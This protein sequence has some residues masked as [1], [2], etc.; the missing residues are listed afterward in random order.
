MTDLEKALL[1]LSVISLISAAATAKLSGR[2][3]E[4]FREAIL[5]LSQDERWVAQL[6]L[7]TGHPQDFL[8]QLMTSLATGRPLFRPTGDKGGN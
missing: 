4:E 6:E 1:N 3:P 7:I 8:K 2:T 5:E